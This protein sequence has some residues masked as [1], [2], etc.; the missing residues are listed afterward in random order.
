MRLQLSVF[1]LAVF[2]PAVFSLAIAGCASEPTAPPGREAFTEMCAPYF[3]CS[4]EQYRYRDLDV[5]VTLHH[6]WF[7]ERFA[8]A[9]A[10]GLH[11]DLECYLAAETPDDERCLG[12]AAYQEEHA[13]E[14]EP[15]EPSRCGECQVVYGAKQA[16]EPCLALGWGASDCAQGLF[17]LDAGVCADPCAPTPVGEPCDWGT[18]ICGPGRYCDSDDEVCR[19][20]AGLDESCVETEC[21]EGL[22]CNSRDYCVEIAGLDESCGETRCEDGLECLH[23]AT[24]MRC[25]PTPGEGEYC[26]GTCVGDLRCDPEQDLCLRP[27][28]DGA[29]CVDDPQCDSWL[30]VDGSCVARPG[31]GQACIDG[32]CAAGLEC[33]DAVCAP[34]VARICWR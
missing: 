17:C 6:A 11:T 5:C 27:L 31:E 19:A 18:S 30:C 13:D 10:M 14:P 33:D 29:A 3:D 23:L 21:E 22:T 25:K 28:A 16:G 24:G 9:A 34:E 32:E 4:C 2:S 1:F 15:R 12:H 20:L 26:E 7:A 8:T